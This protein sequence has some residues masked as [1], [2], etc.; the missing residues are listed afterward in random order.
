MDSPLIDMMMFFYNRR[1]KKKPLS[2]IFHMKAAKKKKKKS[3]GIADGLKAL[4]S[5]MPFGFNPSM[6]G[7]NSTPSTNGTAKSS[8]TETEGR[9]STGQFKLTDWNDNFRPLPAW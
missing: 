2:S 6:F 8:C 4:H 3:P 9:Q 7:G 5:G 1:E